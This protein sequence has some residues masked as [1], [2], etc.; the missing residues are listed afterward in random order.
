MAQAQPIYKQRENPC[1]SSEH[2]ITPGAVSILVVHMRPSGEGESSR[3][4]RVHVPAA[5]DARRALVER[6]AR[7]VGLLGSGG[8]GG[9]G[10]ER[11]EELLAEEAGRWHPHTE[12]AR[13]VDGLSV[14]VESA[15]AAEAQRAVGERRQAVQAV[16][17][18]GEWREACG[19]LR[20]QVLSARSG[21]R[22]VLSRVALTD[23]HLIVTKHRTGLQ[24]HW[25]RR[26][27]IECWQKCGRTARKQAFRERLL[28]TRHQREN[29]AHREA[30][31]VVKFVI[32]E[33][34]C[35]S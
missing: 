6:V 8:A 18:L 7:E 9:R 23:V 5:V 28:H 16:E 21:R 19:R 17:R 22:G 25:R 10:A 12:C 14:R 24:A 1:N 3:C 33:G 30:E 29:V 35:H 15:D 34:E 27:A 11:V 13:I 2:Q 26:P 20:V 4:L 31:A 32:W